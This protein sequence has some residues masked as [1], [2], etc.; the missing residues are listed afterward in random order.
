MPAVATGLPRPRGEE[1][2]QMQRIFAWAHS[3]VA[4][5][6]A[7]EEGQTMAEYAVILALITA[8]VVGVMAALGTNILNVITTVTDYIVPA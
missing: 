8:A 2:K 6:H 7:K 5:L 4:A 1:V 3:H